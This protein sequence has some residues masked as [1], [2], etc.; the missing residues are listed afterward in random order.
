MM[1]RWQWGQ[2]E[3]GMLKR[4]WSR[5]RFW[6][7]HFMHNRHERIT[8]AWRPRT[9]LAPA[10]HRPVLG[11][12]RSA[13]P[14]GHGGWLI[15]QALAHC[16]GDPA[17]VQALRLFAKEEAQLH[18]LIDRLRAQQGDTRP[19]TRPVYAALVRLRRSLGL[20]FELSALLL[21]ELLDLAVFQL[22]HDAA[23]DPTL[24]S[25]CRQVLSDRRAHAAFHAERLTLEFADFNFLRRNL[26]RL[27]LRLFFAL[28]LALVA[29]RH[30]A[31]IRAAGGNRLSF[32]LTSWRA[33]QA[34]L[35]RVVPYHR[36]ALLAALLHQ[37][38]RPYDQPAPVL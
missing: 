30:G 27:R 31:L 10:L 29:L 7:C 1:E 3:T 38:Q 18:G 22:I 28:L 17:Y 12:L 8:I 20:R 11:F 5:S 35:E 21:E 23:A 24:R 6:L 14:A 34:I 4:E 33:F 15:A 19:A 37:D 13:A 2:P 16:P 9:P 36:E 26:R 32:A 25:A